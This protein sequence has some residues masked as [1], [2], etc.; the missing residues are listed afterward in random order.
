MASSGSAAVAV[1]QRNDLTGALSWVGSISNGDPLGLG[2]IASLDGA[3]A[4]A[5]ADDAL[6]LYSA[7][8]LDEAVHS[9]ESRLGFRHRDGDRQSHRG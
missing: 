3:S 6:F 8:S 2:V 9:V 5:F 1:F 4:L 7:A